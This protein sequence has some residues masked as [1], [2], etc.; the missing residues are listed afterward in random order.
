[1][2][3]RVLFPEAEA[4]SKVGKQ[5]RTQVE[6]SGIP[7]GTTGRVVR[8]EGGGAGFTLGIE[9]DLEE[10]AKPLVDWFTKA[11]FERFLEEIES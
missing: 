3:E 9:W 6:F 5:I 8:V 4:K 1:M 7:E 10:R 2:L 11:E